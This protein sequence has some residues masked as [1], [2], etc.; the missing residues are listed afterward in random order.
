MPEV[1][2][3]Q[4]STQRRRSER[5][6]TSVPVIVRGID[7][8]GQ[9]F[10]ERTSTLALNLHGCR[11]ASKHHLPKNSWVTLELPQ[12]GRRRHVRARVAWIQRP[13]SV[14]EFFQIAVELESPSD[15]WG[16][17][18][19]PANWGAATPPV[20]AISETLPE[21]SPQF[22]QD[23]TAGAEPVPQETFMEKAAPQMTDI[24]PEP[25]STVRSP[26]EVGSLP[27][28]E[29]PLFREWSAELQRQSSQ[30]ADAAAGRAA[31]E[32]RQLV[33]Q[34][35]RVANDARERFSA[36]ISATQ[37]EFLTRLKTE[38]EQ[39]FRQTRELLQELDREAQAL[40]A[41]KELALESVSRMAQARLQI[42]AAE[43]A[44]S[45]QQPAASKEAAELSE[46]FAATWRERLA[47]EMALAQTQWNELLQS[48]LDGGVERLV[49]QLSG[50]SQEV[51]RGA[52]QKMSERLAEIRQPLGQ[53]YSEARDTVSS[54]RST[55]EQEL[56]RA[57]SSLSEI[58]HS[59][60]RMKEYSAQLEAASHDSLNELHRRLENILQAQTDEMN[61]R[62]ESLAA[63]MPQRLAP[64]LDALGRQ[65]VERTV[66]DIEAELAPRTER[67]SRLLDELAAREVEADEGLRLHR[68]RL[69]QIA[70]NNQRE[71]GANLAATLANLRND[72]EVARTEAL[73]KWNEELDAAGVRAS[74]A[75][76]E[77][78]G[79]SS[80]WFQQ[81]ARARLQVLI[82]QTLASAGSSFEE[83]TAEAARQFEGQL[84]EQSAGHLAQ[85][86]QQ[87]EG[88]AAEIAGRTRGQLDEAAEAAA[89]SFGQVLGRIS[90]QEAQQF[91]NAS[92]NTM[93]ERGRDFEQLSRQLLG[94]LETSAAAS[95]DR[96][97]QQMA[98][99]V[100]TSVA[101]GRSALAAEFA[102]ALDGYRAERDS[103]HREWIENLN[104]A[105]DEF[106]ERYQDRLQTAGDSWVVS[107]VRRLNEHGQ[108]AIESLMRSADQSLRD[109]CAKLFEGISETLRDR[110]THAVTGTVGFTPAPGRDVDETPAPHNESANSANA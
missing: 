25:G 41:E 35:E 7:L 14:R 63:G 26:L 59:A 95:I 87:I 94:N 98:T 38:F 24:S 6:S 68:E 3:A 67:V 18:S 76:A 33:E 2:P 40:R 28:A 11:Y 100:G 29:S 42:E 10:E 93:E 77:S 49:A 102:S 37:E 108:N 31:E 70:E 84:H 92:H 46:S 23:S 78:I 13:H 65:L 110:N 96:F 8:L 19:A 64:S 69:R 73:T 51:L 83:K 89:A 58:E 107:S 22:V 57:R 72:F 48:S 85:I 21:P 1:D 4:P 20:E 91:A 43:A 54:V 60:S 103:H 30:A 86:H 47:S 32:I 101:E 34:S 62:V 71:V 61:R 50:R 44:R 12:G 55:L 106:V 56:A 5:I 105:S 15:I 99:Q 66:G 39:G 52:E 17:E 9:P 45:Q 74:H 75:A 88:V 36:Q 16:I 53:M 79:R 90:E 27:M 82:E 80:E 104:R 97:N 81:E 109:S